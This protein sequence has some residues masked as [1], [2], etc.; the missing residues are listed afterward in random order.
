MD[1]LVV[2]S[3][4]GA[5]AEVMRS[6]A[7]SF[8]GDL[9]GARPRFM[10]PTG[11]LR[12]WEDAA[13]GPL[14]ALSAVPLPTRL[15]LV[16]R[17]FPFLFASDFTVAWLD[18][19]LAR[20]APDAVLWTDGL[21]ADGQGDLRLGAAALA[22]R[23]PWLVVEPQ[24]G[25]TSIRIGDESLRR[26]LA[27][28]FPRV[29]DQRDTFGALFRQCDR[30]IGNS[31]QLQNSD[32]D[33]ALNYA[34]HGTWT[35][36]FVLQR[37]LSEACG[38]RPARVLELGGGFGFLGAELA[39]QGHQVTVTDIHPQ[40]LD[41]VGGWLARRCGVEDRLA[42]RAM[43]MERAGEMGGG[44]DMIAIMSALLYVDRGAIPELLR[45][46]RGMLRPGGVFALY[47]VV[48][49]ASSPAN[50]QYDLMFEAG[51]LSRIV[52]EN[53]GAAECHSVFSGAR[54]PCGGTAAKVTTVRIDQ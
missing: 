3:A 9:D 28:V 32:V 7:A 42:F 34:L 11:P 31:L 10:V 36:G 16:D 15:I 43:P 8:P 35:R 23:A 29:Y 1:V 53:L 39:L 4:G 24:G 18:G 25:W 13:A 17:S 47:E 41:G 54:V 38:G 49:E 22:R 45:T 20:A 30:E 51:E 5:E 2:K 48:R 21:A 14:S 27:S 46:V 33:G 40:R 12:A 26:P 44:W 37:V 50:P 19:L 6:I 52:A